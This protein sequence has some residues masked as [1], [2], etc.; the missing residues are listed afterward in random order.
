[1]LTARPWT[2]LPWAM[3]LRILI[4]LLII[5]TALSS[6]KADQVHFVGQTTADPTLMR[7]ALRNVL[8]IAQARLN[9]STLEV[10]KSEIMPSLFTPP[11]GR[12]PEGSAKTTYERWTATL[13]GKDVPFLLG[14]WAA[15]DGGTMFRVQYPFP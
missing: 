3:R 9:C 11:G 15:S 1:M 2:R 13:C 10:V 5:A 12:G 6:A 14:F 8:L 4:G 7:D